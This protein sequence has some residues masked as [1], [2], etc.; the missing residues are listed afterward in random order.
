MKTH[1]RSKRNA[2]MTLL[3]VIVAVS[4]FSIA[5]LV[6]FQGFVTS[7][8]INKTSDRYLNATVF[9]QNLMED[10]KS[11]TF[12]EVSLAFNYPVDLTSGD[13]RLTSLESQ[14]NRYQ[15]GELGIRE[16]IKEG[17]EYKN[18]RLYRP[19]DTDD[20]LVT[21]SVI[22]EDNGK[23]YKFNPREKGQNQSRYYFQLTDAE[24]KNENYDALI[25]FDGS[26]TSGYKKASDTAADTEK[27]DYLA[28]NI[29]KLDTET[30]AFLIMPEN[31]DKNAMTE[32]V[33]KQYENAKKLAGEN[34]EDISTRSKLDQ[35]DVYQHTKRTLYVKVEE[36][37]GTVKAE[38]KYVLNA[39]AYASAD[40]SVY[41]R[42]DICPKHGGATHVTSGEENCIYESAYTPFY[43]S[44]TGTELKS[45]YVFYYPNYNSTSAVNPLDEIVF[46]NTSN[47]PVNLYISKQRKEGEDADSTPTF[48]QENS[49]RMSLTVRECPEALGKVNWNTNPGL[50]RAQTVL[51]TNLDYNISDMDRIEE[52]PKISQMRLTYQGVSASTGA[53]NKRVTGSSAKKVL[54][55][56]GL[57]DRKAIDRIYSAKVSVYKAGAAE[58]GFPDSELICTLDGAKEN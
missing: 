48:A 51:R 12:P 41:G 43:S 2:G 26:K 28:P 40:G 39:N 56:N 11:K 1:Q 24:G 7:G 13:M 53:D 37:G 57:D 20:S 33:E 16:V 54:N 49:Y 23:T 3:E 15:N 46:E 31:W 21:A 9:A 4:I 17:D 22:S 6:L 29:S 10:I 38:A 34:G 14:K 50:F 30:N 55:Y 52:R 58:K 36:S 8:R 5:A 47:Y 42:M 35:D 45:I 25:E 19:A 18:V 32:L 27:N 44:E